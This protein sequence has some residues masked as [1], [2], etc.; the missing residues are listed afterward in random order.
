MTSSERPVTVIAEI[1]PA[2][3]P[4]A[5]PAVA[6]EINDVCRPREKCS[7]FF[8]WLGRIAKL[9]EQLQPEIVN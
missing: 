3:Y 4:V 8:E 2:A 7:A 1:P 9:A 6:S 5:G